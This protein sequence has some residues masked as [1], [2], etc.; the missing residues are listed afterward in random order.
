MLSL[1]IERFY[2]QQLWDQNKEILYNNHE[3]RVKKLLRVEPLR[4]ILPYELYFILDYKQKNKNVKSQVTRKIHNSEID[5]KT[6]Q[7]HLK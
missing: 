4:R 2:V 5:K 3:T 7:K 1:S 6:K